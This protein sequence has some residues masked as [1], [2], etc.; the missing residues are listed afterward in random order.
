MCG[1][2]LDGEACWFCEAQRL[3]Q[4]MKQYE[5]TV[6]RYFDKKRQRVLQRQEEMDD[7]LALSTIAGLLAGA[8]CVSC[9]RKQSNEP[10]AEDKQQIEGLIT[11]MHSGSNQAM[12]RSMIEEFKKARTFVVKYGPD[13]KPRVGKQGNGG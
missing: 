7:T 6:Q 4:A 13:G 1:R 8:V 2:A 9:R 10:P 12:A 3:Q 11:W 5:A